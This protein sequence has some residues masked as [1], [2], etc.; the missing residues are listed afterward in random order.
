MNKLPFQFKNNDNAAQT[1]AKILEANNWNLRNVIERYEHT[2][3]HPG[4]EF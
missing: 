2:V 4:T 3:F 1:K